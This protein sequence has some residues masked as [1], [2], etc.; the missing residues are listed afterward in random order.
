MTFFLADAEK[1]ELAKY[2]TLLSIKDAI[3]SQEMI[4]EVENGLVKVTYKGP[5]LIEPYVPDDIG[6]DSAMNTA[7]IAV[8][9][10]GAVTVLGF[11]AIM[12]AWRKRY[13]KEA[14]D[15][16]IHEGDA[17]LAAGSTIINHAGLQSDIDE[18]NG[19]A[20]PFTEML[21]TAYRYGENMSI[22]S[23]RG[24]SAVSEV[25]E[26]DGTPSI[27]NTLSSDSAEYSSSNNESGGLLD[28][29]ISPKSSAGSPSSS[30]GDASNCQ[31]S[32]QEEE[33]RTPLK[34][35]AATSLL[36][37]DLASPV[38]ATAS[39]NEDDDLLFFSD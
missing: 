34:S 23:G 21:P 30:A 1:E 19:S 17:T 29:P 22:L 28:S 37:S 38:R 13:S 9:A 11:L 20:S 26:S 15:L 7:S 25:T 39:A 3:E 5:Q 31:P 2:M 12:F 36:L 16:V 33:T 32:P 18:E 8:L 6:A 10:A 24:L 14:S 35:C 27:G 4:D